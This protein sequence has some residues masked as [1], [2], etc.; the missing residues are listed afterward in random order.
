MVM[1][2]TGG[3]EEFGG[4]LAGCGRSFGVN[5]DRAI[6]RDRTPAAEPGLHRGADELSLARAEMEEVWGILVGCQGPVGSADQGLRG[7]SG[8]H[9]SYISS[10]IRL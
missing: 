7:D 8:L 2:E 3:T 6:H 10:S 1:D 5:E 9:L 4:R